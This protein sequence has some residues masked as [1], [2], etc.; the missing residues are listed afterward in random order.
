MSVLYEIFRDN[1]VLT[2]GSSE[3]GMVAHFKVIKSSTNKVVAEHVVDVDWGDMDLLACGLVEKSLFV[4]TSPTLTV[5]LKEHYISISIPKKGKNYADWISRII[6]CDVFGGDKVIAVGL[7]PVE[8]YRL[9]KFCDRLA[10]VDFM[11][12]AGY[13]SASKECS[14][15]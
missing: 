11:L 3:K 15:G 4:P 13:M 7:S 5:R 9:A 12:Q 8:C 14:H 2:F 10:F 1:K 6:S